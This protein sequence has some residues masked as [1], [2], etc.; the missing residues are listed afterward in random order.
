MKN[1]ILLLLVIGIIYLLMRNRN[2]AAAVAPAANVIP[3]AIVTNA[4]NP[5]NWVVRPLPT[6]FDF[7]NGIPYSPRPTL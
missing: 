6:M 7:G 2:A 1:A 5:D 3:Q 4:Q